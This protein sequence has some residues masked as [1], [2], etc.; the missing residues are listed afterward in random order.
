HRVPFDVT[1]ADL[2]LDVIV[3]SPLAQFLEFSLRTPDGSSVAPPAAGVGP[4]LFAGGQGLGFCR[5][6]LPARSA[7][8]GGSHQGR[9]NAV[10]RLSK[11]GQRAIPDLVKKLERSDPRLAGTLRQG[12]VPYDLVVHS[13]SDLRFRATL[14]ATGIFVGSRITIAASLRQY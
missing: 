12:V 4:V 6:G 14:D 1:E 3:I 11:R 2:G 8:P 7:R 9:W 10:L 5:C 13:Q